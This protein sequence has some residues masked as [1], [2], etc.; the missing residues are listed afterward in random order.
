MCWNRIDSPLYPWAKTIE[1]IITAEKLPEMNGP[2]IN[3]VSDYGG[4]HKASK[5]K[6]ISVLYLDLH[7]SVEWEYL[8]RIVR[9]DFLPDGRRLSF[10]RLSDRYRQRALVPFLQAANQ[11]VGVSVT[12]AI[13][14]SLVGI[15]GTKSEMKNIH[16]N[17]H[18]EAG[19]DDVSFEQVLMVSHLVSFL[20][21]GLSRPNQNIYWIS[22]E[23][24]MFA[25]QLRSH[26]LRQVISR[27]S[28]HYVKHSLGELGLG[29][30]AIDE[31]DRLEEDLAAIPDL[32]AGAV[33]EVATRLSL[34]TRG[35][36]PSIIAVPFR[37]EFTPKT[38]LITSWIA[39]RGQK[40]KRVV[41]L[42]EESPKGYAVGRFNMN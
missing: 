16:T 40:L 18:L 36:I 3:L 22:D 23:D 5:Y 19:W 28:S 1:R 37:G 10:K 14:K 9:R 12:L 32:I 38:E 21:A 29:T 11:I 30:T 34:G 31:G 25:N 35:R 39:D 8:R 7:A 4:E 13:S 26:D 20:I 6:T 41:V 17:L 15:C 27:Y 42:F 33:S 2:T 24:S